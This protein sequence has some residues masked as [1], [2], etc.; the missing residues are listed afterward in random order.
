MELSDLATDRRDA[1]GVL[2]EPA[3]VPVVPLGRCGEL[4]QTPPEILVSHEA[5]DRSLQAGVRDLAGEELEETLELVCVPAH[6]RRELGR[7][8]ALGGLERSDLEL[9]PIAETVDSPED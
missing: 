1:H 3:R 9:E 6:R 4:A 7:I 8:E 5:P 2:E